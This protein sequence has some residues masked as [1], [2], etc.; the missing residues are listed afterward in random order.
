MNS[1]RDNGTIVGDVYV[2]K[3]IPLFPFLSNFFKKQTL[4]LLPLRSKNTKMRVQK[5]QTD[6]IRLIG[7]MHY[8]F[9]IF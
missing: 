6:Q 2:D 8:Y 7:K 5:Y 9:Y 1:R 4:T 3:F